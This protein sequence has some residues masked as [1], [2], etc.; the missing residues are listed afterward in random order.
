MLLKDKVA[1][2]TGGAQGIGRACALTLAQ[3]G[4]D[5]AIGDYNP[6]KLPDVVKEIEALGRSGWSVQLNVADPGQVKAAFEGLLGRFARLDVMVNNAG[7]TRDGLLLRMKKEEWD[8]VL[9]TNL[10]GVFLCTQEAI[11]IMLKQRSGRIINIAS[12]VALMGNPGQANYA[13]S[14]AGVVGLTKTAALEVASRNITV[15]AIAPGFI[16]TAMTQAL[17][18]AARSRLLERI[19]LNRMGADQDVANGVKFLASDEA[20]YITGHVLNISGGMYL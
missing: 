1:F 12:V 4:A 20:G 18:D 8:A 7:I 10:T 11:K 2:V 9:Q 15:N 5:V 3:A 19:P 6:V 14:K 13:A 17:P 16:D